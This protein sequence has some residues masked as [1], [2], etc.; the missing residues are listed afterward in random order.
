MVVQWLVV[1]PAEEQH[2]VAV[3]QSSQDLVSALE[4]AITMLELGHGG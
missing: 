1:L 2:T 3:P 4:T